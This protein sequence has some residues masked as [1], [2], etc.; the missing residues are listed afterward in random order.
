MVRTPIPGPFLHRCIPLPLPLESTSSSSHCSVGLPVLQLDSLPLI[1]FAS[2]SSLPLRAKNQSFKNRTGSAG[3]GTGPRSDT[4]SGEHL[5]WKKAKPAAG[6]PVEKKKERE[7]MEATKKK[8]KTQ[9][10]DGSGEEE[11]EVTATMVQINGSERRWQV[12]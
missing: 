3:L 12:S 8:K 10:E 2:P 6:Q 7:R 5:D 1:A 11:E 9:R 4:G